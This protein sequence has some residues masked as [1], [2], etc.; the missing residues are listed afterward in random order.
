[1]IVKWMYIFIIAI[2]I[3]NS[4]SSQVF[5]GLNDDFHSVLNIPED[6][7]MYKNTL[8]MRVDLR[9]K[10]N[11]SIFSGNGGL[12]ELIISATK[13]GILRP[14]TG[15]SLSQRMPLSQ[16]MENLRIPVADEGIEEFDSFGD[17]W[18]NDDWGYDDNSMQTKQAE[19][20][21]FRYKRYRNQ[22]KLSV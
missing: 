19:F 10:Q 2:L 4:S 12:I 21:S 13:K 14:Y 5:N 16:F 9:E 8:W 7:I 11:E 20:F 6:D 1:M 3:T 18:G 17:S 15:D 22:T